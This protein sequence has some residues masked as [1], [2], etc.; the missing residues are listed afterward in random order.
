V[1][2]CNVGVGEPYRW[3]VYLVFHNDTL[4]S[5]ELIIKSLDRV[6]DLYKLNKASDKRASY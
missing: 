6:S 5:D 3:M 4:D 2:N 1:E